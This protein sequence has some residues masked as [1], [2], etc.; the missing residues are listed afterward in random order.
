MLLPARLAYYD[1]IRYSFMA[2]TIFA[3][4]ALVLAFFARERGLRHTHK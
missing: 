1:G 2:S 4:I 3:L